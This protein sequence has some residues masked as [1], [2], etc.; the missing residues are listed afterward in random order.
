MGN[1]RD[2]VELL[3]SKVDNE[4]KIKALSSAA[5]NGQKDIVDLIL[6]SGDLT[7]DRFLNLLYQEGDENFG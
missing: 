6:K 3:V 2:I 4:A 1:Q 7:S 5:E